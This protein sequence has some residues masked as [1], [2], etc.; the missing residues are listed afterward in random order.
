MGKKFKL[1]MNLMPPGIEMLSKL[2]LLTICEGTTA[3]LYSSS[4]SR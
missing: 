4:S 2:A 3:C 1:M